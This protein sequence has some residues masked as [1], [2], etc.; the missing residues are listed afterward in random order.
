M[1]LV[2]SLIVAEVSACSPSQQR[3]AAAAVFEPTEIIDLGTLVTPDLPERV[4]GK[5]LSSDNG[6]VD[7]NSFNVISW[8]QELSGGVVSG[9]NLLHDLQSWWSSCRRPKPYRA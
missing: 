9:S 8:E 7:Q 5:A 4:W 2:F 3:N 1:A 6:Y